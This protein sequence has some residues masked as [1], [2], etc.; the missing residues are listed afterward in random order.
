MAVYIVT[1]KLG[2]GKS[3]AVIQKIQDYCVKGRR[4]ATNMNIR[5]EHLMRRGEHDIMRLP[6]HPTREA[7]DALGKGCAEYNENKFGGIFLDEVG[8][9][10]NSRDWA[11]KERQKMINWLV[12]A[13]KLHW[14]VYMIIQDISLLDKQVRDAFAEHVVVCKR[15]DRIGIPFIG[16]IFRMFGLPTPKLPQWHIAVVKYGISANAPVVDRWPYSGKRLYKAY[17]TGQKILGP[18]DASTYDGIS[19]LLNVSKAPYLRRP[20]GRSVAYF[21]WYHADTKTPW[22]RALRAVMPAPSVPAQL[23]AHLDFLDCEKAGTP[24][25]KPLGLSIS[26]A[27]ARDAC[28]A[29]LAAGAVPRQGACVP[30]PTV[31]RSEQVEFLAAAE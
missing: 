6:D 17:D 13:R 30:L 31:A 15:L 14:D 16:T 18:S 23:A 22:G 25:H 20:S 29:R 8:T 9:F 11:D 28:C 12:H 4:I 26:Q 3:L 1:G 27:F 7:L 19:T 5:I 10:L 2:S 21:D 24:S